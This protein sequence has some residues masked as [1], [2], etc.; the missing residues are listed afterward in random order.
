MFKDIARRERGQGR[1]SWDIMLLPRGT[2]S[3]VR[4]SR[5]VTPLSNVSA[6]GYVATYR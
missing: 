1:R 2:G 3:G 4:T 6:G 5:G